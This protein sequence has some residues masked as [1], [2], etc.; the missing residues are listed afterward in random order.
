MHLLSRKRLERNTYKKPIAKSLREN[1][2]FGNLESE[3]LYKK[4]KNKCVYLRLKYVKEYFQKITEKSI[5]S[6]KH[7][8]FCQALFNK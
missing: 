2:F 3:R 4:Q 1:P 6:K 7:L 8:K 5:V